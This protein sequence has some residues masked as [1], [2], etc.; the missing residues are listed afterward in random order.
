MTF[1]VINRISRDTDLLVT[2]SFNFPEDG[3]DDSTL[4]VFVHPDPKDRTF[5]CAQAVTVE[6]FLAKP[7]PG[8]SPSAEMELKYELL[9]RA[10]CQRCSVRPDHPGL[11]QDWD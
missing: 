5:A 11:D 4:T 8:T 2:H 10:F 9:P 6:E 1:L 3:W 7:R